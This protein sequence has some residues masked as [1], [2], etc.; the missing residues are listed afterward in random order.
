MKKYLIICLLI[1]CLCGCGKKEEKKE[2]KKVLSNGELVCGYKENRVNENVMYTSI[3]VFNYNNNGILE[4][5]RNIEGVEFAGTLESKKKEYKKALEEDVKS[6]DGIKGVSV[7]KKIED[8]K[9]VF[10]VNINPKEVE[11][12]KK[13][14]FLLNFDRKSIYKIFTS[15]GYTCE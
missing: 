6:Y 2:E 15:E 14:D 4:S 7:T 3:H 9:Y 13:E 1:I 5:V 11:D 8:N 12:D 10:E